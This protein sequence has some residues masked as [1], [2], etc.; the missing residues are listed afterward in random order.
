MQNHVL[1]DAG[2]AD[3][4]AEFEQFA[5]NVGSS[6]SGFSRLSIR[7][8]FRTSLVIA[9]RP[10]LPRRIFQLQNKPKLLRCQ[11]T[12]VAGFTMETTDCQP[13]QTEHSHAQRNRSA[14]DNFGR[15][16]ER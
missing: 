4:Y 7:I 12:T 9:G 15:F 2:L 3:I 1:T 16:T 11:A 13:F 10:G 6:Q 5:V 14:A 8:N